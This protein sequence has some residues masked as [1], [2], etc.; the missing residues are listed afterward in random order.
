MLM[1]VHRIL[2]MFH[3]SH[4]ARGLPYACLIPGFG[5]S[6]LNE[7]HK[8]VPLPIGQLSI[9]QSRLHILPL[10]SYY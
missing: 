2:E 1:I 6:F 4:K 8:R 10:A 9:A 7:V 3:L 5:V